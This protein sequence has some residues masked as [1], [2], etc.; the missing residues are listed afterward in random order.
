MGDAAE[1]L[2]NLALFLAAGRPVSTAEIREEIYGGADNDV[3]FGRMFERDKAV[4]K[5][6]GLEPGSRLREGD[7]H[8]TYVLDREATQQRRVELSA[9]ET[10]ALLAAAA[11]LVSDP[12]FPLSEALR[13]AMV[14]VLG[15]RSAPMT[16]ARLADE[17]PSGQ[18]RDAEKLMRH[19]MS[20]KRVAFAY[21]NARGGRSARELDPYGLFLWEGRWYV[22][23]HDHSS[24][25]VRVFA[26]SRMT[27]PVPATS[28]PK[29]PDFARPEGFDLASYRLLPFQYGER[30]AEAVLRFAHE[31]SWRAEALSGGKGILEETDDGLLWR[32]ETGD[33]EALARWVVENGPGIEILAPQSACDALAAGLREA[34]NVHGR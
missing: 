12:A 33:P 2:V 28:R 20:R 34:V 26:V 29:S 10:D 19:A 13:T 3:A 23:G 5:A 21:V 15:P 4:L 1:R 14:K 31:T 25:E 17:R 6:A 18:G 30:R 16:Q 9:E 7:E 32:V 8:E 22:V 24:G 27:D 11:A